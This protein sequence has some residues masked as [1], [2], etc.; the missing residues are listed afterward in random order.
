MRSKS[1]Q[2]LIADSVEITHHSSVIPGVVSTHNASN[3]Y[4]N[5]RF[6]DEDSCRID[7][8]TG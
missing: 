6:I 2:F 5:I 1:K 4:R 3:C 7:T 8:E